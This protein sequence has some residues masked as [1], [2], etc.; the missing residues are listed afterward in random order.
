[1]TSSKMMM[2]T[3]LATMALSALGGED[4]KA[5]NALGNGTALDRNLSPNAGRVNNAR[6]TPDFNARNDIITGNVTGGRGFQGSVGYSAANDFRGHLP[7][8]DL[9]QFRAASALSS[10]VFGNLNQSSYEQLRF[11]ETLGLIE[12]VRTGTGASGGTVG[13]G[14]TYNDLQVNTSRLRLDRTAMISSST[15]SLRNSAEPSVVGTGIDPRTGLP[16]FINASPLLGIS[17]IPAEQS[18]AVRGLT[19]FDQA[20]LQ[21]DQLKGKP[22]PQVGNEFETQ[23][24]KL[25]KEL[26]V[27]STANTALA[28]NGLVN[29]AQV[30]SNSQSDYNKLLEQIAE[31][32]AKQQ[33][34]DFD[35]KMLKD[36]DQQYKLMRER[37]IG[38]TSPS[39]TK[40][41]KRP[42]DQLIA[43]ELGDKTKEKP[44]PPLG[45][46]KINGTPP[47]GTHEI[48]PGEKPQQPQQPDVFAP[49]PGRMTEEQMRR[50]SEPPPFNPDA[51][52]PMLKHGQHVDK[53]SGLDQTRLDELIAAGQEKLQSGEYFWAERR[54]ER[55]LR[56]SPGHPMATA[57]IAHSQLGAGLY[58][59]AALT[60]RSLL[61][62]HPEM[63][64][65]TY[66]AE[67]LPSRDRLQEAVAAVDRRVRTTQQDVGTYSFLQ[68]Y[69]G[70]QLG[71]RAVIERGLKLMEEDDANSALLPILK[72]VWLGQTSSQPTPPATPAPAKPTPASPT[73]GK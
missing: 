58:L 12:A 37:L 54:F 67:A 18:M 3:A 46:G 49:V 40:D 62:E 48:K 33:N 2:L 73:P 23:F 56:L 19:T 61:A 7:S 34:V 69:I 66:G 38:E 45:E 53:L 25:T 22:L 5:Q 1:M 55:A 20:R 41:K 16:M 24:E 70:R 39:M 26:Q 21:Q 42:S 29:T 59:S 14:S 64:D 63:I 43:T 50:P 11:G 57:G 6:P 31:R 4:T 60:L 35:P 68:A 10:P 9:F 13:Q 8:N 27:D 65:V 47:A 72:Q 28:K 71:D 52:T 30:N 51:F 15:S 32:Y 44:K 36:L 17:A